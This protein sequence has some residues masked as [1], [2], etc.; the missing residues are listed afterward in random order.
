MIEAIEVFEQTGLS[1]LIKPKMNE[2]TEEVNYYV[3]GRRVWL[4]IFDGA[5]V[6]DPADWFNVSLLEEAARFY[7]W[8]QRETGQ[9][10]T[11]ICRE[12]PHCREASRGHHIYLNIEIDNK[13]T[14]AFARTRFP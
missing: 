2:V 12:V 7:E 11:L 3:R 8:F 14:I 13:V 5:V 6:Q 1:R 10:C 4:Q 9:H